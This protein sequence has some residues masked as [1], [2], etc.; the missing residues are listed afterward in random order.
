MTEPT[1]IKPTKTTYDVAFF[2]VESDAE[3]LHDH[4]CSRKD[5]TGGH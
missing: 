1:P 4:S 5:A 3:P 2:R